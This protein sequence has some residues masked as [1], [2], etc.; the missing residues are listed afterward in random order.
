[1][2]FRMPSWPDHAACTVEVLLV[3]GGPGAKLALSRV[4]EA[5]EAL[6]VHA[7][8][9]VHTVERDDEAEALRFVGSP[10]V[11][12]D[13]VD[14]EDVTGRPFGLSCRLYADAD[15]EE[16]APSQAT[17]RRALELALTKSG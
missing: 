14:V 11:R 13:G 5:T 16:R 6:G 15:G 3:P 9:R 1:M 17:I 12:V 10:T 2:T 8:L 4:Q 7:N